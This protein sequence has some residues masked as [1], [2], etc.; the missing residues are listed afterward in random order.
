MSVD[1]A[2]KLFEIMVGIVIPILASRIKVVEWPSEWKFGVVF[3]MSLIAAAVVPLATMGNQGFSW[4]RMLDSL[5]MIFTTTQVVYHS[6]FKLLNAE[7]QLNPRV[8]LLR[9]IKEQ[10]SFYV[11]SLDEQK[12]R[13]ILDPHSTTEVTVVLDEATSK[14][15]ED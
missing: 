10:V 14:I 1:Q 6:A 5:V 9:S 13:E 15:S 8:A 2:Q 12:V 11:A 7:D 4:D 3:G